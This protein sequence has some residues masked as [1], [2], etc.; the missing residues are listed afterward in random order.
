MGCPVPYLA[1]LDAL[2]E[3][4]RIYLVDLSNQALKPFPGAPFAWMR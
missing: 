1:I 4:I 2:G 3:D